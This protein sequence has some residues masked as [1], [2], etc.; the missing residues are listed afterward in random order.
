MAELLGAD[1]L[2]DAGDFLK[3]AFRLALD[4]AVVGLLVFGVY[5]RRGRNRDQVFTLVG[6]NLVTFLF[7]FT[8]RNV[9]VE[10]GFALGLFAVFGVLRYRTEPV[11][12]RDLTY[13][14]LAIGLAILNSVGLNKRTSLAESL[15]ADA[16]IVGVAAFLERTSLAGR[17]GVRAVLYDQIALLAPGRERELHADLAARTGLGVESV[18]VERLDLL[19]D[20]AE[21]VVHFVEPSAAEPARAPFRPGPRE[22]APV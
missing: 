17:G 2:L 7:C 16:A 12:V 13:L 10:L 5:L 3:L 22:G 18:R 4:L 9:N 20:A 19:R 14:F 8:L 11:S 21:I 15:L 6:I 1:R